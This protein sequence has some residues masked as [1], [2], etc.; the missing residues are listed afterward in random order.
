[1]PL[2][3]DV[4]YKYDH[5]GI[6]PKE[7][8]PGERY[9]PAFKMFVSGY[10]D[11]DFHVQ[12]HRYE[13]DCELHPLIQ[14]VPH[15]AFRV[16]DLDKAIEGRTVILGPYF[17]LEGYRVAMIEDGGA[18]I[19]FVQTQLTEAQIIERANVGDVKEPCASATTN[20]VHLRGPRRSRWPYQ[21]PGEGPV[22][23]G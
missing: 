16:D 17:P 1:M 21:I 23:R 22:E 13:P 15:V 9:V 20:F 6:P 10:E 14:T 3:P 18:P 7:V 5:L 4:N 12:W 19:E 11:S 2:N 8:R